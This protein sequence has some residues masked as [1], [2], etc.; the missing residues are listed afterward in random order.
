MNKEQALNVL[1]NTFVDFEMLGDITVKLT[2]SFYLLKRL[3]SKYPELAERYFD[4]QR[5]K[6]EEATNEDTITAFY[7]AYVCANMDDPDLMD[8]EAFFILFP[9]DIK[10]IT[11][12]AGKLMGGKKN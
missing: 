5:K 7:T 2:F 4:I 1:K 6:K 11:Q 3:E 8:E 10:Y 9:S 12:V